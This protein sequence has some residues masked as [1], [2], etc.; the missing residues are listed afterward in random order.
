MEEVLRRRRGA[1]LCNPLCGDVT[2]GV[3]KAARRRAPEQ[4]GGQCASQD[5]SPPQPGLN[6][7]SRSTN[8]GRFGETPDNG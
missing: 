3:S 5:A 7:L 1:E 2:Q 8:F 6:F 4:P